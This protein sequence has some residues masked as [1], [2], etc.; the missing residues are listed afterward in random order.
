MSLNDIDIMF[1]YSYQ[2]SIQQYHSHSYLIDLNDYFDRYIY[3]NSN[4][5]VPWNVYN[6]SNLSYTIKDISYINIFNIFDV[7]GDQNI[8][9]DKTK[10]D[11]LN[12]MQNFLIILNF[13]LDYIYEIIYNEIIYKNLSIYSYNPSDYEFITNLN[14]QNLNLYIIILIMYQLLSINI[15]K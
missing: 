12:Y 13:K 7:R 8:I 10:I 2:L 15:T 3:D 9:Y 14:I 5:E 1:P 11:T 4:L 6:K